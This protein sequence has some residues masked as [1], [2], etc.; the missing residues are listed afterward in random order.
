MKREQQNVEEKSQAMAKT[1]ELEA[2]LASLDEQFTNASD[3]KNLQDYEQAIHALSREVSQHKPKLIA[4]EKK[5]LAKEKSITKQIA[6]AKLASEKQQWNLLF[7]IIEE[8]ISNQQCFTQHTDYEQ[9][10]AFWQKKLKDLA[11]KDQCVNRDEST[12][13]LEILSGNPSPSELQQERMTVQVSLMQ[14]QM[15]SGAAIDLPAKFT[16]WLL[17]GKFEE[18]DLTLLNRIKPI[19]NS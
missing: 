5:I 2:G 13:A 10:S 15:L 1:A 19:F 18:Q 8:S 11:G 4:L 14:T 12:L 9:L 3:L 6:A 17:A 16:E 7:S